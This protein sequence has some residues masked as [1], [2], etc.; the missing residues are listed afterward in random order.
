MR[1]SVV[2]GLG[3]VILFIAVGIL[4]TF[5]PGNPEQDK[6]AFIVSVIFGCIG[7]ASLVYSRIKYGELSLFK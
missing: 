5:F 1:T 2:F 3:L 6:N 4:I 7:G